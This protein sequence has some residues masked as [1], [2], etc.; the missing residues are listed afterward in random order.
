M[1]LIRRTSAEIPDDIQA[2]LLHAL[3]EEQAGTTADPAY[4]AAEQVFNERHVCRVVP[5]PPE[6]TLFGA[7]AGSVEVRGDIVGP[8]G[9]QWEADA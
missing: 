2:A 4:V 7:L 9:E 3:K 6:R 8:V 1:E 5:M